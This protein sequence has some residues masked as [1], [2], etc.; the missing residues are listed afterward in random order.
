MYWDSPVVSKM[1]VRDLRKKATLLGINTLKM[2]THRLVPG[3]EGKGKGKG[4]GEGEGEGKSVCSQQRHTRPAP[5]H[6]HV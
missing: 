1:L 2:V 3:W 4:K 6:H 5:Q